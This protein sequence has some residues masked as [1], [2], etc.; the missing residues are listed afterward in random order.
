[1]KASQHRRP[2]P[3]VE[4]NG[5]QHIRLDVLEVYPDF[6]GSGLD[7]RRFG[8]LSFSCLNQSVP[9]GQ[10]VNGDPVN[11]APLVAEAVDPVPVSHKIAQPPLH[12]DIGGV[13]N[14]TKR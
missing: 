5:M 1:M 8:D 4:K 10:G 11:G 12:V 13:R 14:K 2:T 3:M 7:D 9:V 6:T